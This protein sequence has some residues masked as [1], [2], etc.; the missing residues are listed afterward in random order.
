MSTLTDNAT[1]ERCRSLI[2]N[3]HALHCY[4]TG[5]TGNLETVLATL[6][7][8]VGRNKLRRLAG[9]SKRRWQ[10][11]EVQMLAASV[12]KLRRLDKS[13]LEAHLFDGTLCDDAAILALM[14]SE[15]F[16]EHSANMPH[17]V[18]K[19]AESEVVAKRIISIQRV[20]PVR[21]LSDDA[22]Q[23]HV[24]SQREEFG[25]SAQDALARIEFG[26]AR[27]EDFM[28]NYN[29]ARTHITMGF[30]QSGINDILSCQGQ[31]RYYT[32]EGSF[33]VMEHLRRDV[34]EERN[35]D[36][37]FIDDRKLAPEITAWLNDFD[38][39]YSADDRFMMKL[40]RGGKLRSFVERTGN[41]QCDALLDYEYR[42]LHQALDARH[43]SPG[44]QNAS[45]SQ[46]ALRKMVKTDKSPRFVR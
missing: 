43:F 26:A 12:A 25:F 39:L 36:V 15:Y 18:R 17:L 31:C 46:L 23:G 40:R 28:L 41:R 32:P 19:L 35:V 16:Y 2:V 22:L 27:Q 14:R 11:E 7:A 1:A 10:M 34:V 4:E 5:R 21:H 24:R 29:P 6:T 13:K 33:E 20:M 45:K 42:F 44:S 3:V 38:G 9:D 8:E 30:L 37:F